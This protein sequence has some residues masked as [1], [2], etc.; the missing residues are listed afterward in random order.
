MMARLT[1]WGVNERGRQLAPFPLVRR[2][3]RDEKA[4]EALRKATIACAVP[5]PADELE[6][7]WSHAEAAELDLLLGADRPDETDP[8][9]DRDDEPELE[10]DDFDEP[11]IEL[12][13]AAAPD[14]ARFAMAMRAKAKPAAP[15]ARVLE[16]AASREECGRCG[17][18]GFKGCAH[19]G[20][21][22]APIAADL[23]R[24]SC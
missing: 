3:L 14:Y 16:P 1:R 20:A 11:V 8:D 12:R 9:L 5:E 4:R 10:P 23:R 17:I 21:Y 7:A 22:L 18:P 24:L 2:A 13:R 15:A 6:P 19:Q